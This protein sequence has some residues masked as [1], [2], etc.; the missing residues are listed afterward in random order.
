M[1]GFTPASGVWTVDYDEFGNAVWY[2]FYFV[3]R[4]ILIT[5]NFIL[6]SSEA[7]LGD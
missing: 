6:A 1:A 5:P 4:Y 2:V 7:L 3:C